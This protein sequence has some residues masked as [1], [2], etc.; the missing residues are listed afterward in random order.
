MRKAQRNASRAVAAFLVLAFGLVSFPVS[1]AARAVAASLLPIPQQLVLANVGRMRGTALTING[2]SASTGNS[3]ATDST[4]ETGPDTTVTINL[5][6][7]GTLDLAPNTRLQLSYNDSGQVKVRLVVGC[8]ILSQKKGNGEVTTETGESTGKT[9]GGG[10]PLDVC[11]P[12]GGGN[13]VVNQGAA[14]S[15]IASTSVATTVGGGGL[16]G[17]GTAGTIVLI[18]GIGGATL[19]TVL[20]L[21]D[22]Q[23]ESIAVPAPL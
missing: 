20:V 16:F 10:A 15:A 22:N 2:S 11:I 18:G 14:A 12:A 8:A 5:G 21:Q 17:L 7:L 4:I 1:F 3:I 23:I 6:S 19:A 13:P 9:T